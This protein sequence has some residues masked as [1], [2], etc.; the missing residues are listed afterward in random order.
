MYVLDATPTEGAIH[1]MAADEYV[2]FFLDQQRRPLIGSV[3]YSYTIHREAGGA[4]GLQ[5]GG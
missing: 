4:G 1:L 5:A 3:D 2:L